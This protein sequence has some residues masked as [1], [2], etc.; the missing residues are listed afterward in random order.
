MFGRLDLAKFH[1]AASTMRNMF[2]SYRGGA[3]SRAGTLFCGFSKQTGRGAPPRMVPF[4]FS[5]NQGLALE[6]GHQYMRVLM[7][8]AFVLENAF[9]ITGVSIASPAVITATNSLSNGDWVFIQGTGTSLD[10]RTVVAQL[11]SG[12]SF[13]A[14]DVY[15]Q[16]ISTFGSPPY[17][18]GGTAARVYTLATPYSDGDLDYLKFT[19]DA[20]VMSLTCWNQMTG[21]SYPPYDL[22]RLADD[23]WTLTQTTFGASI[24]SPDTV[25]CSASSSGTTFYQYA[26]TAVNPADG[27]ESNASPLGSVEGVDIATTAGTITT[28]WDAVPGVAEYN[29]YKAPPSQVAIPTGS[30]FGYAGTAYGTQFV[31]SNIV[32]DFQQVPPLHQDPFAPGAIIRVPITAGG[33]GIT[34]IS[35]SVTTAGGSGLLL[36]TIVESGTLSGIIIQNAGTGYAPGDTITFTT[37]GAGSTPT[38]TL[39]VGPTTGTYPSLVS[40]YQERRVYAGSPNNPDTYWMSQPGSFTNFDYRLPTIPSDAITGT[41][42][43]VEVNGIQWMIPMPGGLVVLT[44]LAAWQVTGAGG[45]AINPQPVTPSDQQAQP[46]AFNGASATV[47][48]IKINYDILFIQ[49]KG[50][51]A[52][53]L[54]YNYWINIYTGTDLTVISAHLFTGYTVR[55]W[56]WAEEPYKVVWAVR[57]DG[58]LLSLTFLK[59]QDVSGWARSDTQGQFWSVCSVTEPPVDAIYF[60]TE[61]FPPAGPAYMIERMDNRLWAAAEN[62]WCVDAGLALPQGTPNASLSASSATGAGI[63]TGLSGIVAGSGYSAATTGHLVDPTGSGAVVT[64]TI[65]GGKLTGGSI[66]G[67]SKYSNP[68]L[69]ISDPTGAGVGASATIVLD[70]SATFVASAGVFNGEM[71]GWVI[72]MGGGVAVVTSVTDT[73]H[74]V[75]N[76]I[77]PIVQVINDGPFR[78]PLTAASGNWTLTEPTNK[79]GG[80]WHLT[81]LSVTG[82][83]DG[84]IVPPTLVAG[85]GS[86]TLESPASAITLGLGFQAQLQSPYLDA[87]TP[88]VQGQRKKVSVVTARI[89]ASR[90]LKISTNQPDGSTLSPMQLAPVWGVAPYPALTAVPNKGIPPYG[91]TVPPLFTGDVRIPV[92]GGFQTPGQVALQQDFPLPLQVLALIPEVLAGDLPQVG[93]AAHAE[94]RAQR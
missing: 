94:P 20:D 32:A 34:S 29:I 78:T 85:D 27:S 4:Q 47:P 44:G 26:V 24:A 80:L 60:A 46:Q 43:S 52:R 63:P 54:A 28:T 50:S 48:P 37:P 6:F 16:N 66:S 5:I 49:A 17:T 92:S 71:D 51:I 56:A 93:G 90:D 86:V 33:S 10:G 77:S 7:D 40:Y 69:V 35:Y 68:A 59:E 70:N 30:L 81:G 9:A 58:T 79:V 72:R 2:V 91:S 36:E 76:I 22:A 57:N 19:Q 74:V 1:V 61:R 39:T 15:N 41:P 25:S 67:G 88:T 73:E 18:G 38:A 14:T 83:A 64:L 23:N 45:S 89:E 21:T 62:C 12:S 3:Y 75:A 13:A 84:A 65:A 31:D 42:W 53:D 82:L 11:V 8:G 87:G 55:Q